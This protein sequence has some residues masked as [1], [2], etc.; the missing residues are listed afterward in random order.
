MSMKGDFKAVRK[1]IAKLLHQP[2][3]D[4]GSAGP[5]LVRL[6]WYLPSTHLHIFPSPILLTIIQALSR[7]L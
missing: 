6:A 5:V 3:Y 2:E 7:N 4:D 1:D